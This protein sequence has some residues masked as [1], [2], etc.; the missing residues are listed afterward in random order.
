MKYKIIISVSI[1][2]SVLQTGKAQI[3][4]KPAT[5]FTDSLEAAAYQRLLHFIS[6]DGPEIAE[7]ESDNDLDVHYGE[8]HILVMPIARG[9]AVEPTENASWDKSLPSVYNKG[10][11]LG[12]PFLLAAYKPGLV[13]TVLDSV[14]DKPD[15]RYNYD[16]MSGNFLLKRNHEPPIAVYREQ[17]KYFCLKTKTEGYIFERVSLINPNEFYQVLYKGPKYSGYKMY[18]SKFIPAGQTTNG[19]LTEGNNYDEYMDIITFYLLDQRTGEAVIFE[20]TKKSLRKVLSSESATV[21]QYFKDHKGDEMSESL[22]VQLL[23]KINQ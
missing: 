21:E 11:L 13:V 8:K 20:I 15:Y 22:L 10:P 19:Y 18:K 12:S 23:E 6:A 17:I 4:S 9:A 3:N 1:V 7:K 5:P 14:I 2:L 16:K